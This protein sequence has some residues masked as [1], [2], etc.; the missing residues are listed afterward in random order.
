MKSAEWFPLMTDDSFWMTV[1][2]D[3]HDQIWFPMVFAVPECVS[4]VSLP[5]QHVSL[6]PV[7]ASRHHKVLMVLFGICVGQEIYDHNPF[8]RACCFM[9]YSTLPFLDPFNAL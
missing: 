2:V 6:C 5:F 3:F 8:V 1:E 7:K 9:L 4:T